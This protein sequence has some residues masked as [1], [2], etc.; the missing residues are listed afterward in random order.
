VAITW[1]FN[2]VFEPL[3]KRAATKT[4]TAVALVAP[5]SAACSPQPLVLRCPMVNPSPL[6][7]H[8][9]GRRLKRSG[10]DSAT[11]SELLVHGLKENAFP[12]AHGPASPRVWWAGVPCSTAKFSCSI[13]AA[14]M[15][16]GSL[17]G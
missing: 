4:V 15:T 5:W 9:T 13:F 11:R 3:A 8:G 14:K 2:S 7:R 10:A 17:A 12:Y 1:G 16:A 6:L